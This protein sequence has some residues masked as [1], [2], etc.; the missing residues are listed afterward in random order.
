MKYLVSIILLIFLSCATNNN[1]ISVSKTI[2]K[3]NSIKP[4]TLD[5]TR[6][7]K[8]FFT[9][10]EYDINE[11]ADI[12]SEKELI[13]ALSHLNHMGAGGK[14][15]YLLEKQAITK[16]LNSLASYSYS[17]CYLVDKKGKIVYTMHNDD[18]LGKKVSHFKTSPLNPMFFQGI[19]NESLIIDVTQ[20]PAMSKTYDVY[21]SK[22]VIKNNEIHGILITAVNIKYVSETLPDAS[23]I[24]SAATGNIKFD[25]D[26]SKFNTQ[27]SVYSKFQNSSDDIKNKQVFY[28]NVLYLYQPFQY[29][30]ISW[31]LAIKESNS[32]ALNVIQ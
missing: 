6:N 9:R 24:I 13:K 17:E 29:K 15:Y 11:S 22:P 32:T 26:K 28:N 8:D 5:Y 16:M 27:D 19:K 20:F 3:I 30:S 12:I 10:C 23:K 4:E 31:V 2:P 14:H 18:L 7:A 1:K 21:F 25:I